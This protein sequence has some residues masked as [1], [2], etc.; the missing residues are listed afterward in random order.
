MFERF[1]NEERGAV[2]LLM[3]AATIVIMLL[4]WVIYDAGVSTRTKVRV[5]AAADTAA[6]SQ[7]AIKAR[8]MNMLAYTNIAKRS[9]WAA[10]SMY[11]SYLSATY[12]WIRRTLNDKAGSCEE[13]PNSRSCAIYR[14]VKQERVR[15]IGETCASGRCSEIGGD[16][17]DVKQWGLFWH[18]NGGEQTTYG[19]T[20][21]DYL[22]LDE[23]ET[24]VIRDLEEFDPSDYG[25][26]T[27]GSQ[28][29]PSQ[30]PYVSLTHRYYAQDIRALDHYQRYIYGITPWWAWVEQLVRGVR[31]GATMSASWPRP[32]GHWPLGIDGIAARLF[33]EISRLW[34]GA[35]GHY[36]VYNDEL[37]VR[38]ARIGTMRDS[39]KRAVND[40]VGSIKSFFEGCLRG[41]SSFNLS[42]CQPST[43]QI[44]P[45][46]LEHVINGLIFTLK[47]T[48]II[49]F[50]KGLLN[51][52]CSNI[53]IPAPICVHVE[54]L[55]GEHFERGIDYTHNSFRNVMGDDSFHPGERQW[56][57]AEPWVM[58]PSRTASDFLRRTS[59]VVMTYQARFDAFDDE[60]DRAKYS[61]GEDY[62]GID[63][64]SLRMRLKFWSD[65][66]NV[67]DLVRQEITY[68]ASGQWGMARGEAYFTDADHPPDIWHP[69]WSARLRPV[70]LGN[71]FDEGDYSMNHVYRDV[72]SGFILGA[73]LGV[74]SL[75]D[76][77]VAF[78]DLAYMDKATSTMTGDT[79][80]GLTR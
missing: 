15:W 65:G 2:A 75:R 70:S 76:I 47:S 49:A 50:E 32:L 67:A 68:S 59:N 25:S 1:H 77:G 27:A 45:F 12:S 31:N 42:G 7:A 56:I 40:S 14:R 39:M 74:S 52:T 64:N 57:A 72:V 9:I 33:G 53:P 5:Q 30:S 8:T 37:P 55:I 79:E 60:Q 78:R 21:N 6:F 62:R 16:Q 51:G 19:V 38:P 58:R 35:S 46:L 44:D 36:S 10:H 23:T 28:W 63:A 29:L 48:G 66:G 20:V 13:N 24:P 4:S 43:I 61:I 3:L 80:G 11:P 73:F 54:A 69:S 34:G 26:K 22:E 17:D 18:L 41:L 71:E